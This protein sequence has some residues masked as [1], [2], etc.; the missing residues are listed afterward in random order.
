MIG[1]ALVHV[2][3]V[4]RYSAAGPVAVVVV[5]YAAATLGLLAYFRGWRLW[6]LRRRVWR[7]VERVDETAD[8][9]TLTLQPDGHDGIAYEAGQFVWLIAGRGP[10]FAESH[11]ISIASSAER[12]RSDPLQLTIKALGDWSRRLFDSVRI[13]DRLWLDGPYGAFTPPPGLRGLVLIAGGVGITPLRSMLLTLRDRRDPRPVLLI[14]AAHTAADRLFAGELDK[15]TEQMTLRV[16][17]VIENPDANWPGES[18]LIDTSLLRRH[19]PADR[20]EWEYFICGPR[21]MLDSV[22]A[23]LLSLGIPPHRI[24]TERFDIV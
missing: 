8:T 17:P 14:Q 9:C 1:A 19:L 16:I 4:G 11:P 10:P 5:G 24:R 23:S 13:G 12:R 2:L 22:E 7:I 21:A 15:L 3:A 18:G 20:A 6:R